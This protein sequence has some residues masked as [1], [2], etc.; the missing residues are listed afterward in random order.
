[1]LV[2]GTKVAQDR[3]DHTVRVRFLLN[4]TADVGVDEATP[5]TVEYKERGS[6]F[7]GKIHK[8]TVDLK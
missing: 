6:R 1:M 2:D 7:T 8:V 3:M 5:V 4:E